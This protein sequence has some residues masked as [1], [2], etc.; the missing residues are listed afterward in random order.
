M[1][2]DFMKI[3]PDAFEPRRAYETDAGWDF[4]S[5][6]DV[7]VRLD[8][9]TWVSTGVAVS[10]PPGFYG[11]VVGRSSAG[12]R[13]LHVVEGVIDAGYHGELIARVAPLWEPAM[14]DATWIDRGDAVFQLIVQP[15]VEVEFRETH[16]LSESARGVCGFGSSG[17]APVAP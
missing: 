3:Q 2:V 10:I 16:F 9:L 5:I 8:R 7:S 17:H 6:N 14:V 4:F 15:V 11:R 1:I 13:G 12:S